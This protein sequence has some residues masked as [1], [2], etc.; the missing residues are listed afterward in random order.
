MTAVRAVL[1]TCGIIQPRAAA[2]RTQ[3][4]QLSIARTSLPRGWVVYV[5]VWVLHPMI[6]IA[7]MPTHRTYPA[8]P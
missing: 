6:I 2:P 5:G 4:Y 1:I 3:G 7:R 8:R